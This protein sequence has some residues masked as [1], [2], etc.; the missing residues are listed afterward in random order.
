MGSSIFYYVVRSFLCVC[1]KCL[2]ERIIVKQ[3]VLDNRRN[4]IMCKKFTYNL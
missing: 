3:R 4:Q 2:L 1:E